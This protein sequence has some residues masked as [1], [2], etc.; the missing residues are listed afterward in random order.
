MGQDADIFQQGIEKRG[1]GDVESKD[2]PSDSF[3]SLLKSQGLFSLCWFTELA[4]NVNTLPR[5]CQ[6][7]PIHQSGLQTL[8]S[9]SVTTHVG[10]GEGHCFWAWT[11][12]SCSKEGVCRDSE[13]KTKVTRDFHCWQVVR[14]QASGA[15]RA[16]SIQPWKTKDWD[17]KS[18]LNP[19]SSTDLGLWA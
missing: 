2:R 1:K 4:G 6:W 10:R 9:V 17:H 5:L 15:Q 18:C 8:H 19:N 7:L 3:L 12:G 11:C 14:L 13:G 16:K